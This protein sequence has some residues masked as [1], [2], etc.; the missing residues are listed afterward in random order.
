[1]QTIRPICG[2]FSVFECASASVPTPACEPLVWSA[3][4]L[5]CDGQTVA[6]LASVVENPGEFYCRIN[7][8]AGMVVSSAM[9]AMAIDF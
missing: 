7:N 1:M 5:P 6:L 4:E 2:A 9:R 3:A 8:P